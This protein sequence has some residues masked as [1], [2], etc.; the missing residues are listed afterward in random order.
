MS[1][2]N[3]K[4]YYY[5]AKGRAELIR[6]VLAAGGKEYDNVVLTEEDWKTEKE[7]ELTDIICLYI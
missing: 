1:T 5:D 2:W 3:F 4:L 7:S 6:L